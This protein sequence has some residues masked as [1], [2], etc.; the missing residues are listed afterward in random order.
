[1][2][3][4]KDAAVLDHAGELCRTVEHALR[5]V[6][7]KNTRWLPAAEHSRQAI[8]RLTSQILRREFTDGLET[9][10]LATFKNVREIY[11]RVIM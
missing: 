11:D 4:K 5:L 6:L 3:K 8:E 1:M 9:E 10:L 7:G 2:L